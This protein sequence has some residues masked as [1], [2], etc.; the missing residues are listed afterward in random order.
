MFIKNLNAFVGILFI[1]C[2]LTTVIPSPSQRAILIYLI[3]QK[4]GLS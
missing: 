2:N 1:C 3:Q 4:Q